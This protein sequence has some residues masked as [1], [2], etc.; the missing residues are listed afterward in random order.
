MSKDKAVDHDVWAEL[1][2]VSQKVRFITRIAGGN[3][4]QGHLLECGAANAIFS[5]LSPVTILVQWLFP[6][7][8]SLWVESSDS[9]NVCCLPGCR[10]GKYCV[11]ENS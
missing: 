10:S 7:D 5:A 3:I 9:V 8:V 2:H 11:F 6:T 1:I 4:Q